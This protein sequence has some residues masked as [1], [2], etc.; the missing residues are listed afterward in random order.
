ML[1]IGFFELL[2]ILLILVIPGV[3]V[4]VVVMIVTKKRCGSCYKRIPKR[5][6]V[7]PYCQREQPPR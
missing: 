7:C 3:V 5:A 4:I 2:I 6:S 1:G